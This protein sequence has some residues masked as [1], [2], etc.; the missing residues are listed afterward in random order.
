MTHAL[1]VGRFWQVGDHTDSLIR[2]PRL[3]FKDTKLIFML[4]F[5]ITV[6][7]VPFDTGMLT[8]LF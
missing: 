4:S 3:S 8:P 2:L 6:Q 5:V 1:K 7:S